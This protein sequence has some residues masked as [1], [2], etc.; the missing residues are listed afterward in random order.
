MKISTLAMMLSIAMAGCGSKTNAIKKDLPPAPTVK[1][2]DMTAEQR[3]D[4]MK[5]TVVPTMKPLFQ[6]HNADK[7]KDFGCK[8]CHGE[9]ASQGEFN[10]P[11]EALPA[12][13][14]Q[15]MAQWKPEDLKWMS[16]VIKPTMAKLL[17]QEEY[18]D[19]NPKGFGCL[20]CHTQKK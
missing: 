3:A 7:F 13:D 16:T 9:G 6:K 8:T 10:M 1:F 5:T 12:L 4:F 17:S 20:E 2:D 19:T 15:D 11:N 18:S 14:F